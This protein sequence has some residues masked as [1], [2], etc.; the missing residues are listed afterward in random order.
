MAII[1]HVSVARQ[2]GEKSECRGSH[3]YLSIAKSRQIS[4]QP[5]NQLRRPRTW[6]FRNTNALAYFQRL[7]FVRMNIELIHFPFTPLSRIDFDAKNPIHRL[8][9][10][11]NSSTAG[12]T[13]L[14]LRL[15]IALRRRCAIISVGA[16]SFAPNQGE[17]SVSY[18]VGLMS[19]LLPVISFAAGEKL[20]GAS[21]ANLQQAIVG[22]GA[23]GELV[24]IVTGADGKSKQVNM[25]F[26][27]NGLETAIETGIGGLAC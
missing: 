23:R 2:P 19:I 6:I 3:H 26:F 22:Q 7:H 13:I 10:L 25:S 11:P 1:E 15:P 16:V 8:G 5:N 18:L 20:A 9:R 12:S 27:V 24:Y 14:R 21:S 4:K 17:C